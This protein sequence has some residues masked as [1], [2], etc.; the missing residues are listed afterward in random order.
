MKTECADVP[1]N[2]LYTRCDGL[3]N[4]PNGIDE[5]NCE[6]PALCPYRQH[7]CI[8]PIFHNITCL[9]IERANDGIIDCMGATDERQHCR[10]S[11]QANVPKL[12]RCWKSSLCI[13]VDFACFHS[14]LCPTETGGAMQ[15]C[16]NVRQPITLR[17]SSP[18][19]NF[20]HDEQLMCSL[21]SRT[22]SS[23]IH[24]LLNMPE[25]HVSQ[26]SKGACA[27]L[28]RSSNSPI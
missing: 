6:W 27:C 24:L 4:C 14:P 22:R 12:Y 26:Q 15:F 5:V 23:N 18:K 20:T 13:T 28:F 7:M 19:I 10:P 17:C 9:P 21:A 2:T 11:S 16:R 8:S 25:H 1:C 3:W